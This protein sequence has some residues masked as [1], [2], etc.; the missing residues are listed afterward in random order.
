MSYNAPAGEQMSLPAH[1]VYVNDSVYDGAVIHRFV[2]VCVIGVCFIIP[3]S[4]PFH[5]PLHGFII[6]LIVSTFSPH[7]VVAWSPW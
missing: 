5:T 6:P 1:P 2:C 7:L 4:F 3:S